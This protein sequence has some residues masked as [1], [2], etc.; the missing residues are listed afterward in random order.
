[1][2]KFQIAAVLSSAPRRAVVAGPGSGKT[3]TLVGAIAAK[4]REHGPKSVLCLTFTVAGAQEMLSRLTALPAARG[5]PVTGLGYCGTLHSFLLRL[6]R[7]NYKLAGLPKSLAVVDEEAVEKML[8]RIMSDMGS[9][10]S[11]KKMMEIISDP[12]LIFGV[13]GSVHTKEG[14]VVS[15]LHRQLRFN[16]LLTLDALLVYGLALLKNPAMSFPFQHLF[17]DEVQDSG[18]LDFEIYQ[19]IPCETK[20]IVGDPDQSIYGFR[21]AKPENFTRL[22]QQDKEWQVHCLESN[23]RCRE[24]IATAAQRLISINEHRI[25][26]VTRAVY[27]GGTVGCTACDSPATEQSV[28]GGLVNSFVNQLSEGASEVAVLCRTNR[29]AQEFATHLKAIGIPVAAAVRQELPADWGTAKLLVAALANP[30]S[31]MAWLALVQSLEGEGAAGRVRVNAAMSM[32]RVSDEIGKLSA[33]WFVRDLP[34]LSAMLSHES[35]ER[36]H[37]ACRELSAAGEWDMADL[38]AYLHSGERTEERKPGVHVGTVHSAKG[39]EWSVVVM[40]GMEEGSFPQAKKDTDIEEER[41]LCFVGITRA[42]LALHFTWCQARPQS[43]GP[44]LPPGPMEPR[45]P[46]RFLQ[47][48]GV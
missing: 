22:V 2:N 28:V 31:D 47:E 48:A 3:T 10:S 35:R 11:L 45:A 16:G 17:V 38:S 18:D 41:R 44:N 1:M 4:C 25:A 8:T 46:S 6:L 37:D 36:L 27:T 43:R 5:G 42:K 33:K 29:M 39:R 14:L 15:E 9:R 40:V 13:K 12:I 7:K 23:H 21:G 20:T 26:K 34:S 30:S 32:S 19:A 24:A